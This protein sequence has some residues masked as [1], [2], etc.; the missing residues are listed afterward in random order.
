MPLP[1]DQYEQLERVAPEA[2]REGERTGKEPGHPEIDRRALELARF[3]G[4][5]IDGDPAL[6]QTGQDNIE[7]WTRQNGGCAPPEYAEWRALIERR[8]WPE[9]R[10]MFLEESDKSS[11][12]A[13][14][15]PS[16]D[17]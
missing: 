14:H 16:R 11:G 5:R 1:A 6:V 7:Q 17:S 12:C 4:A 10:R 9:L 15:I 13:V 2:L 8:P 3:A